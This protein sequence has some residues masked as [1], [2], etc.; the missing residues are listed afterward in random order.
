[1]YTVHFDDNCGP[2]EEFESFD[3]AFDF[4]LR[5]RFSAKIMKGSMVLATWSQENGFLIV[6]G[7]SYGY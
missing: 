1:M 2:A 4:I 6:E 7:M 3:E 5:H